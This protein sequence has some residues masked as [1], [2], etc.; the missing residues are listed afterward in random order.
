MMS[1]SHPSFCPECGKPVPED[2]QHQVCPACLMAQAF[3]SRTIAP[4]GETKDSVPPP[5]PEEI[6][7]KFPQFEITEC[8]GR[9]GMG[10]VYKARQKS[11]DRWVA[12][13]ILPPERV[14]EAK[15]ADRFAR[16]A[17]TLAKLNHPNIVT[18]HDF[19]VAD[20][21]PSTP[22][23]QPLYYIVMEYVDGVNLRDLLRDGKLEPKQALAIVPPIC[24][25]L[26]FAHDKGIV[27]RDIKPENLLLDRDG[28]IKIADFGIAKLMETV[29][30]AGDG[31]NSP[32]EDP[33]RPQSAASVV[34]G[35]HG[36]SAPEQANGS[37]DHRADIYAL[38]VVLYEMLTGE[39]PARN[40]VA[41][42][43]KVRI[44]VRLDEMVLRALDKS[45]ELRYQTADEFRTVVQTMSEPA[46]V[47]E[48]TPRVEEKR[49]K[50]RKKVNFRMADGTPNRAA[51]LVIALVCVMGGA[52]VILA[53]GPMWDFLTSDQ[54]RMLPVEAE[55]SMHN[56]PVTLVHSI[57]S[58][59]GI[60]S[61]VVI[62][63]FAFALVMVE[64]SNGSG[65][66]KGLAV[67]CLTLVFGAII[68][69][70]GGVGVVLYAKMNPAPY[71]PI[72]VEGFPMGFSHPQ[73]SPQDAWKSHFLPA[74]WLMLLI[75]APA[76][77]G[78]GVLGFLS[79]RKSRIAAGQ[80]AKTGTPGWL[81]G[82]LVLA[83]LSLAV[84]IWKGSGRFYPASSLSSRFNAPVI[85]RVEFK[86][87]HPDAVTGGSKSFSY[88]VKQG[89]DTRWVPSSGSSLALKEG[90]TVAFKCR[91]DSSGEGAPRAMVNTS[92]KSAEWEMDEET[93][94]MVLGGDEPGRTLVFA[95]GLRVS[96]QW[97]PAGK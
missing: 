11:L 30:A 68:V 89:G 61:A 75:A 47:P 45:P 28:R 69:V 84:M 57:L 9:G 31:S 51:L 22:D 39:R 5:S 60:G 55:V 56:P 62:A 77:I 91:V 92:R 67:G 65:T 40:P 93:K 7:G 15:F 54:V 41:P 6:A 42:S 8:L 66:G 2:S 97:S 38:G 34:A 58:A 24:E 44:D 95:N 86:F 18:I 87:T 1:S 72:P 33:R 52:L 59:L 13:K 78:L 74:N 17:A 35:T 21:Q 19:G 43:R 81:I 80:G 49:K 73:V 32:E 48:E 14:G 27:H 20:S 64:K 53:G 94:E 10:V 63:V 16:E 26:Q 71:P 37:A 3:A 70:L 90:Q 4:D 96:V 12:I 82:L 85:G 88:N 25:A 29:A 46:A 83:G 36:Y 50:R 79:W 23:S 76:L